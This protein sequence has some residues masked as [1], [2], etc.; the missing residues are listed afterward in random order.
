MKNLHDFPL[1]QAFRFQ[2]SENVLAFKK[3]VEVGCMPECEY[4]VLFKLPGIVV[5]SNGKVK[6]AIDKE[7]AQQMVVM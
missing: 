7:T 6:I 2:M 4:Q 5:I 1:H 3:L